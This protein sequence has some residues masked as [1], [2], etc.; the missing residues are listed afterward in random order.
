MKN[1]FIGDA[2][3]FSTAGNTNPSLTITALALRLGEY[4]AS[5]VQAIR[6]QTSVESGVRTMQPVVTK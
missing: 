5:H 1:L 6:A 2:S 3:V 4:L